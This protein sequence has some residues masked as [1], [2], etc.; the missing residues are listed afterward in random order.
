MN[1]SAYE[2]K[3]KLRRKMTLCLTFRDGKKK[4]DGTS[5]A[6]MFFVD[7][8]SSFLKPLME[9]VSVMEF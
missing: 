4:S 8:R 5:K 2:F 3:A 1:V 6:D 9:H 7:L